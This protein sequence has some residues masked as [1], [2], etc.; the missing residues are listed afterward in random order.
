VTLTTNQYKAGTVSYLNVITAQ[1]I[2]L[3]NETTAVQILG[4]AVNRRVF[5]DGRFTVRWFGGR[6]LFLAVHIAGVPGLNGFSRMP[7]SPHGCAPAVL[8][9]G[10]LNR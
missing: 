10:G 2:A 3:T 1:T 7:I 8:H 9:C 6:D 5:F 4:R